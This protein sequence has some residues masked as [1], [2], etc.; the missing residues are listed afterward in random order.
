MQTVKYLECDCGHTDHLVKFCYFNDERD[1]VYI[2]VQLPKEQQWYKRIWLGLR[3][4]F[5]Y[6]CKYGHWGESVL[7]LK[8]I[9]ELHAFLHEFRK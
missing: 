2:H 1:A 5:G 7:D 3:Y 6:Q 4:I 8:K 9:D